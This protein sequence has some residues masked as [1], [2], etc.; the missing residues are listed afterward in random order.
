MTLTGFA[1][2][3]FHLLFR[4]NYPKSSASAGLCLVRGLRLLWH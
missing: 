2:Q 1:V 4:L 3:R